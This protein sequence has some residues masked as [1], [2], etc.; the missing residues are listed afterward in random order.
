MQRRPF[1]LS[2]AAAL[3][4]TAVSALALPAS[5]IAGTTYSVQAL[6]S[7]GTV[8]ADHT[9]P[10]LKNP[11]GVAFNPTGFV[12]LSNNH[13]G[14]STL[15]DG[16][17][18]PQALVV[19]V[20]PAAGGGDVGSPTG[21]VYNPGAD[22]KVTAAGKTGAARF[23]FS[24]E[25]GTISGWAPSVD[26]THAII[27]VQKDGS[28]FK[29]LATASTSHGNMLYAADF[30]NGHVVAYD[31]NFQE[32][33]T[34]G[35]FVDPMLHGRYGPFNVQA[36]GDRLYVAFAKIDKGGE[37]EHAG[38]GQGFIDTFDFDG[39]LIKRLVKHDG[40]NAPWGFAL[41]PTTFG[42][43]GGALLV[44]NFGDGTIAAYNPNTGH[45]RGYLHGT[46]GK[47]L[48]IDGLWGMAFGNGAFSQDKNK[49]Y[50]AAGVGSESGGLYGSV[51][52]NVAE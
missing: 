3:L 11:W 22:F 10:N 47:K 9:D 43:Y 39:H 30:A 24:T 14:T 15:Y 52:V 7:D 38:K 18:V 25:D 20:P 42:Q 32:V 37:D 26:G 45:L 16:N 8:P 21:I 6:V 27:A 2:P 31:A 5:A 51:S 33:A 29:G 13:S 17:G 12:W 44:G 23:I 40:V 4:A 48:S 36:I 19:T 1:L 34:D 46:D 50:F 41:A 49:L 35:G 28:S